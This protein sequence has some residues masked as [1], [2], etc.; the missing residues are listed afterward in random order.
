[1]SENLTGWRIRFSS[2]AGNVGKERWSRCK[3]ERK[4]AGNFVGRRAGGSV[5]FGGEIFCCYGVGSCGGD[6][7]IIAGRFDGDIFDEVGGGLRGKYLDGVVDIR[8]GKYLVGG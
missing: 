1:M 4:I 2:A 6:N 3:V 7:R 8:T 5:F